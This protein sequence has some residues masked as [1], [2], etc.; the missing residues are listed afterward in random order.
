MGADILK[1]VAAVWRSTRN[2][3]AQEFYMVL[4][5]GRKSRREQRLL[6]APIII[7][8]PK[9]RKQPHKKAA[10]PSRASGFLGCA[11]RSDQLILAANSPLA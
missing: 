4:R 8:S 5:S 11:K 6:P 9:H 1:R 2:M 3:A 10:C 7:R